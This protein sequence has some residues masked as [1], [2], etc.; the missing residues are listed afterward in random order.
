MITLKQLQEV[1]KLIGRAENA[2]EC[3]KSDLD[4]R[5]R[6]MDLAD[7]ITPTFIK[8]LIEQYK[9]AVDVIKKTSGCDKCCFG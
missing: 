3:N 4:I 2:Q 7:K 6:K 8:Q 9:E 1:E 5:E